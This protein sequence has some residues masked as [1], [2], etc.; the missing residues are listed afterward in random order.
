MRR[1]LK[2]DDW[3]TGPWGSAIAI[4]GFSRNSPPRRACFEICKSRLNGAKRLV[5]SA[6]GTSCSPS[7]GTRGAGGG[8]CRE[9]F[10]EAHSKS[11][12]FLLSR[13][14]RKWPLRCRGPLPSLLRLPS[15]F[16]FFLFVLSEV[17]IRQKCTR[18]R[19]YLQHDLRHGILSPPGLLL[20]AERR[21]W[22]A[23]I[24]MPGVFNMS[25]KSAALNPECHRYIIAD[26][27]R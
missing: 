16:Y 6:Q 3:R 10:R 8:G 11:D 5:R 2:R 9:F 12:L 15:G 25:I 18:Q 14:R 27:S 21:A 23:A 22:L 4:Y 20:G 13:G 19:T 24:L 1:A 26:T 17:T 7:E